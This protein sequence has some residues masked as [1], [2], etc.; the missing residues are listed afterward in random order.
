MFKFGRKKKR[1]YKTHPKSINSANNSTICTKSCGGIVVSSTSH[2]ANNLLV[3][4][5][6]SFKINRRG[7]VMASGE[8]NWLRAWRMLDLYSLC[9]ISVFG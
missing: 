6:N 3:D 5:T 1:K 7:W 4:K 2:L 9:V 8:L